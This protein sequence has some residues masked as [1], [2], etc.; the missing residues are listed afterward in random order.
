MNEDS[1]IWLKF[2]E[3]NL[4]AA[5][6]LSKSKLFNPCLQNIQQ[7]IE[8]SLKAIFFDRK[9]PLIKTH[10]ILELQHILIENGVTIHL[11]EEECEFFDSIYLPSKYPI[12]SA[13]PEFEPDS[14]ITNQAISITER[15]LN[16][17]ISLIDH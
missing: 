13:L 5:K 11:T 12:G 16:D 1:K 15:V 6:I 10:S 3:E 2:S 17:I 8:K 14:Q 4:N 9:I 7:C